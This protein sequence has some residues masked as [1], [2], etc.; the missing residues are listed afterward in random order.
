MLGVRTVS[1]K[2]ASVLIQVRSKTD[3]WGGSRYAP[4]HLVDPSLRV[5]PF[6]CARR[7]AQIFGGL[8]CFSSVH[9]ACTRHALRTAAPVAHLTV[10]G[11]HVGWG[12]PVILFSHTKTTCTCQSCACACPIALIE[13][14]AGW[15]RHMC[16]KC[17]QRACA[18]HTKISRRAGQW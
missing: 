2:K 9:C 11:P 15:R 10:C 17:A 3:S 18:G 12:P 8:I 5:R 6:S 4:F 1:V 16:T 7:S 14:P 13:Q